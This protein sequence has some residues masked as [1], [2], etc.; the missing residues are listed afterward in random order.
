MVGDQVSYHV[1]LFTWYHSLSAG[2]ADDVYEI[3]KCNTLLEAE[4]VASKVMSG[5][6]HK[7]TGIVEIAIKYKTQG[8]THLFQRDHERWQVVIFDNRRAK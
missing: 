6:R 4:E 3:V 5:S 8:V 7:G 1:E 2:E